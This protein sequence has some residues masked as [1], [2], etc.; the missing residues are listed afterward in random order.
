MLQ[1][2]VD[3][4]AKER[5]IQE[6]VYEHL[7]LLDPSWERATEPNALM[8]QRFTTAFEKDGEA[9]LTNE[10][11]KSRYDIKYRMASGKHVVIELKRS[12]RGM[13]FDEV[14]AQ[15]GKYFR[16]FTKLLRAAKLSEPFEIVVI[17]GKEIAEWED[18][19]F[20][21][22]GTAQLRLQNTRVI[23]YDELLT[24]SYDQYKAYLD[25]SKRA[26]RIFEL[27]EKIDA[28]IPGPE[29]NPQALPSP[30]VAMTP[31]ITAPLAT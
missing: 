10:E 8:E 23:N 1:Q 27:I 13:Y 22:H 4:S 15:T 2:K 9:G 28:A 25:S 24:R 5:A 29:T 11:A 18:V 19:A 21:D 14:F 17:L 3:D 6:H 30:E 12:G 16:T 26:S 31:A 20:K 7:W